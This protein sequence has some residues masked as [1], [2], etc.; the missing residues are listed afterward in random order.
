MEAKGSQTALIERPPYWWLSTLAVVDHGASFK[1]GLTLLFFFDGMD[2]E[3][4]LHSFALC[5]G[6]EDAPDCAGGEST[7]ADEHRHIGVIQNQAKREMIGINFRHSE[8]SFLRMIDKLQGDILQKS[9]DLI[10]YLS[11]LPAKL[12]EIGAVSRQRCEPPRKGRLGSVQV[13]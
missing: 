4:D 5:G 2:A 6:T 13:P 11:H 12:R 8:L 1:L 3:V 9:S 10:G 7:A